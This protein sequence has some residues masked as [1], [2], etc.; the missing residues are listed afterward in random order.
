[1][2]LKEAETGM[3]KCGVS[4]AD[5]QK[6]YTERGTSV[7]YNWEEEEALPVRAPFATWRVPLYDTLAV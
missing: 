6:K 3:S 7:T 5:K 1:M 2:W 4:E